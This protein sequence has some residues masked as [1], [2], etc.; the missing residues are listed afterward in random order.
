MGSPPRIAISLGASFM[1]YAT[2]AGFM[3]Q[4][5]GNGVRPVAVAGSSAGAITSGLYAAG[6]AQSVIRDCVLSPRLYLSFASRTRWFWHHVLDIFTRR[7]PG[8]FDASGAVPYFESLVGERR[9]E[10]LTAP[11][12]MIAMSD[13]EKHETLYA[14]SGPLARAMAASSCVPTLFSPLEFEGRACTD[15][16]VAHETPVD[17]WFKDDDIDHIILHRITQPPVKPPWLLPGRLLT[18]IG[19][20][21]E[22]LSRQILADRIELAR[23]SGKKL[24]IITTTHPRPSPLFPGRLKEAYALGEATARQLLESGIA[25]PH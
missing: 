7:R 14:S 2:H 23:L 1:G 24:S 20:S 8:F 9:I 13:L 3:A 17:P 5:H 19:D 12:L 10:S 16:G 11:R 18:T 4:L 21:H 22:C 15:G 25:G 6:L